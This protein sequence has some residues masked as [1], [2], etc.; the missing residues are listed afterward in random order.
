MPR[1]GEDFNRLVAYL[2]RAVAD[3]TNVTIEIKKF[4]PDKVTG[5]LRE[6]DI[7]LTQRSPQRVTV[8][9]IECRD[10]NR[11][12]TVNQIE[13]FHTKCQD[14]GIDKRV[15]VSSTGFYNPARKKADRYGID[16]LTFAQVEDVDWF[17][18]REMI[19]RKREVRHANIGIGAPLS[20]QGKSGRLLLSIIDGPDEDLGIRTDAGGQIVMENNAVK[21]VDRILNQVPDPTSDLSGVWGIDIADP[22]HYYFLDDEGVQHPL[23]KLHLEIFWEAIGTSSPISFHHYGAEDGNPVFETATTG[24]E[25]IGDHFQG[26]VMFIADEERRMRVLIAVE[27]TSPKRPK[28]SVRSVSQSA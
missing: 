5:E 23:K 2:E 13:E 8:T 14:T 4:V 3:H 27:E 1:Q 24:L 18:Q 9:A 16:C 28:R 25:H 21:L 15:I 22:E 20:M 17:G 7:V 6:H 10:R 12:V 19:F 26:R 11:P